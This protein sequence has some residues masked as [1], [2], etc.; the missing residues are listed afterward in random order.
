MPPPVMLSEL[1]VRLADEEE[2]K[3]PD[4]T[5]DSHASSVNFHRNRGRVAYAFARVW[6]KRGERGV[7]LQLCGNFP[8]V[9]KDVRRNAQSWPPHPMPTRQK[10]SAPAGLRKVIS[11]S[12]PASPWGQSASCASSPGSL[13]AL[14]KASPSPRWRPCRSAPG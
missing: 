11:S 9:P 8:A 4:G 13:A 10:L 14:R 2:S 3:H 1:R 7:H 12:P 6:Q 5:S